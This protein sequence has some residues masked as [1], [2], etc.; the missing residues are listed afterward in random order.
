MSLFG[1]TFCDLNYKY[2]VYLVYDNYMNNV[3]RFILQKK[4]KNNKF[5]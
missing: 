3:D 4:G 1:R 5:V 2:I